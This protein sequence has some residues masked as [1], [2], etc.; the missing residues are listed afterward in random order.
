M[1]DVSVSYNRYN[2]LGNEFLTW[3]WFL[4]ENNQDILKNIDEQPG[5]LS[6]GNRIVL[7][8]NRNNSNETITIKGDDAGLEEGLLSLKKGAIVSELNL[9]FQ[10]DDDKLEFRFTIKGESLNLGNLKVPDTGPVETKKNIEGLLIEK[11]YLLTRAFNILDN[12]FKKFIKLRV[13]NDWNNNTVPY[14]AE[15]ISKA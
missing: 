4:I 5:H 9:V 3:L 11:T 7:E 10:T 15:W 2:F 1:L 14:L 8:N 6:V 12:L 13:S